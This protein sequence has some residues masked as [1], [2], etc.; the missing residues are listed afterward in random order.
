MLL[1]AYLERDTSLVLTTGMGAK[2]F[3]RARALDRDYDDL[4]AEDAQDFAAPSLQPQS[5]T[6]D[7]LFKASIWNLSLPSSLAFQKQLA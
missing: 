7:L 4:K 2:Y 5:R 6:A 3:L 1:H